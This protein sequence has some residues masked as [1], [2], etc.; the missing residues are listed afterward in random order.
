MLKFPRILWS[1]IN[2]ALLFAILL[3]VIILIQVG[4]REYRTVLS[5][6][7]DPSFSEEIGLTVME[8]DPLTLQIRDFIKKVQNPKAPVARPNSRPM[9]DRLPQI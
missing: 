6:F 8:L 2:R 4:E 1:L 9:S 3:K 7:R 5:Q